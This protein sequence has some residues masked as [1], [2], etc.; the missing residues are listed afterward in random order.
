MPSG[1][2]AAHLATVEVALVHRLPR[3]RAG[4]AKG[5]SMGRG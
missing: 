2:A 1:P 4:P 5:P 3:P